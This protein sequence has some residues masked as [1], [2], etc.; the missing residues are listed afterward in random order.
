MSSD[1]LIAPGLFEDL[2]TKIDDDGKIK[3]VS[4]LLG[5]GAY[6]KLAYSDESNYVT[7]SKI[8]RKKVLCY[9]SRLDR[10]I[11]I[12]R[13]R[14]AYPVHPLKLSCCTKQ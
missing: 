8:L 13:C 12:L 4:I 11:L 14:K 5:G 9:E 10:T 2:Q 3:D 1:G 7:S 6:W